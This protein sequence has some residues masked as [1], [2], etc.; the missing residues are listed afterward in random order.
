MLDLIAAQKVAE[1]AARAAG[2]EMDSMIT[3]IR[4]QYGIWQASGSSDFLG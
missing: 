4:R 2:E 3:C 1:T